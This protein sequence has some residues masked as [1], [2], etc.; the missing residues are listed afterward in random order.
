MQ[1]LNR[2]RKV[3][4]DNPRFT[5]AQDKHGLQPGAHLVVVMEGRAYT[6]SDWV[7]WLLNPGMIRWGEIKNVQ[8]QDGPRTPLQKVKNACKFHHHGIYIGNGMVMDYPGGLR[9]LK[10][11]MGSEQA[12]VVPHARGSRPKVIVERA[13][14]AAAAL[15]IVP[16]PA[17]S[18]I[19]KNCEHFAN[20]IATGKATS[21]QIAHA[22]IPVM[23]AGG[24]VT[25]LVLQ[26]W[27]HKGKQTLSALRRLVRAV[28]VVKK[29]GIPAL[30]QR[31]RAPGVH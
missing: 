24:T 20:F 3:L 30:V 15:H 16:N 11:F 21:L 12:Y 19:F 2:A 5:A 8:K 31:A 28:H 7:S 25:V 18:E 13:L 4:V 1:R 29:N 27:V 10:E 22:V 6:L 9:T 26:D 14:Q 17:Y 23:V